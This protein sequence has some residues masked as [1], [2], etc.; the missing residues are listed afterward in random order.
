MR[1]GY[2]ELGLEHASLEEK[3]SHMPKK[4]SMAG[5][6]KDDGTRYPF[7][8]LLEEALERHRNKMMDNFAQILRWLPTSDTSTSSGGDTPFKVQINF[9]IPIF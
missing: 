9:G 1:L 5:E 3:F 2:R 4:P 6:N 8:M 7:K